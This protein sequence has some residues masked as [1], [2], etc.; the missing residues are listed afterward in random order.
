MNHDILRSRALCLHIFLFF[1]FFLFFTSGA[2]R[3]LI[4]A[5]KHHVLG[6]DKHFP[7]II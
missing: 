3:N 5:S 6:H 2:V 7:T 4:V 1:L